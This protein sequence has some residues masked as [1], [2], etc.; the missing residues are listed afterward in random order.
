MQVPQSDGPLVHDS[1]GSQV[2]SPQPPQVPQSSGQ[3]EQLSLSAQI[4]L[5][6]TSGGASGRNASTSGPASKPL[7]GST[8]SVERPQ[9][10]IRSGA[11]KKA[12]RRAV[13]A[14]PW[15]VG[16]ERALH[17][18]DGR[19]ARNRLDEASLLRYLAIEIA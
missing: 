16:A 18:A 10:A 9:P 15:G 4:P 12:K 2:P 7:G 17:S 14:G 8:E 13:I 19:E 11:I 3:L 6:Q 1:L 5:P